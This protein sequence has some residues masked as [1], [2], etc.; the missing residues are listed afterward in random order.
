MVRNLAI[1]GLILLLLLLAMPM[2]IGMAMGQCPE[3]APGTAGPLIACS[4]L[5]VAISI[6]FAFGMVRFSAAEDR[7]LGL[8]GTRALERPP[9]SA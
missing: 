6:A 2:G 8:L 3:C 4:A 5:L 1:V 7:V 9:R